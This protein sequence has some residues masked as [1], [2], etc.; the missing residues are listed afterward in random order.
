[1][2]FMKGEIFMKQETINVE[3]MELS[4]DDDILRFHV[5]GESLDVNLNSAECQNSLK[6]VF[7][8]LLRFLIH[9]DINLELS[10]NTE[11][12]RIMYV[13]VCKEYIKDLNRELASI[14]DEIRA[15][16]Q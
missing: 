15:E 6:N 4:P 16:L 14:K 12:K 11:Y 3:L 9:S 7:S 2:R 13:E 5:E 8:T 10:Y 1:M